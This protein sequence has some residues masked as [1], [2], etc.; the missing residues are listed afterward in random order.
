MAAGLGPEQTA[1]MRG[2][3]WGC[4]GCNRQVVGFRTRWFIYYIH[5][6]SRVWHIGFRE[7]MLAYR[8][9]KYISAVN[10][11]LYRIA[12]YTGLTLSSLYIG[13]ISLCRSR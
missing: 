4:A 6:V 7:R 2:L 10:I 8:L 12:Y 5:Y 11:E 1:R 9:N 3:V 13:N